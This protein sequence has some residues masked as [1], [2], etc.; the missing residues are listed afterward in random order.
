MN[1]SS[2]FGRDGQK[3]SFSLALN[4]DKFLHENKYEAFDIER[5]TEIRSSVLMKCS[6]KEALFKEC[7]FFVFIFIMTSISFSKNLRKK[8]HKSCEN[9]SFCFCMDQKDVAENVYEVKLSG[10]RGGE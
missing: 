1:G 5:E 6:I 3:Y 7:F 4:N 10:A 2:F 9:V 8:A